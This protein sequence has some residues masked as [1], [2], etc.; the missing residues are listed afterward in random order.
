MGGNNPMT[1]LTDVIT[2]I[3][4]RLALAGGWIDQPFVSRHDPQPP[5]SMVVV[6]VEPVNHYMDRCGIATS[7][8]KV[9]FERWGGRLPQGDP[10]RLVRELYYA[11]NEGK[12]EPSGSQD[13]VGLIYPGISRLDYDIH[14]EGGYFP[15][16]IESTTDPGIAAWLESVIHILPLF[17][18]PAG[19]NP[20]GVKNLQPAWVRRLGQAGRDC[21]DAILARDAHRLGESLNEAMRCWDVLLPYCLEHPA[22]TV[23]L[24]AFMAYYR[25][26][27]CGVMPS[28]MGGGYLYVISEEPVPGAFHAKIRL[29]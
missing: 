12:D 17:P 22:L 21:Y 23:D 29:K 10:A 11:E 27:Y 5:G 6:S 25:E 3:P 7:T 20:L 9:A 19:Y 15:A 26:R 4:Y 16:H 8:R 24:K 18:R 14:V 13:M 2:Q 1:E 28:G